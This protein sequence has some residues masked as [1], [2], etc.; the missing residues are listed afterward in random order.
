MEYAVLGG[1]ALGLMA[2]YRLVEAGHTVMLFEKEPMAGGLAAGFRVGEAWLDKFYHHI[3]RSDTT[4]IRAI[5]ELGLGERLEWQRPRTVSL[6]DGKLEQLDSPLTLLRFKP[7][8]LDE[9][10]RVG[11]VLVLFEG[12]A[13][14]VV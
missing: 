8:R 2:A 3:F 11:A 5:E 6:V 12:R 4:A 9:R 10:L 14:R 1:G 7:W 13:A